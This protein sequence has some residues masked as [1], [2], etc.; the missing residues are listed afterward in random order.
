MTAGKRAGA[1]FEQ[2]VVDYLVQHGFPYA[3][4]RVMGGSRDR[5]DIAGVLGWTLEAKATRE[6]DLASAVDE[7]IKESQNAGTIWYA[8]ILKRRR[9][10]T[11]DAYVVMPL[12]LFAELLRED[13]R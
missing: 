6:L 4:R 7:T 1:R 3:E 8:A 13:Q 11:A 12:Y 2:Q 9:K 10:P 5:G